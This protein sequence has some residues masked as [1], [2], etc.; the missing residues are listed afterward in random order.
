MSNNLKVTSKKGQITI[1]VI[2]AIIIVA[3]VGL[4]FIISDSPKTLKLSPNIEPVYNSFLSCLE[5]NLVTGA[6]I[7][8]SQAGYIEVPEFEPGSRYMPFSSQLDFAGSP[9]P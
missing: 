4:I 7:L 2:L 9:V 8:G 5:E 1:F 6:S 3:A